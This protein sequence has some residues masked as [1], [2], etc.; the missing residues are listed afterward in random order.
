MKQ[1]HRAR[2][3]AICCLAV[4]G[5]AGTAS[6][7]RAQYGTIL[8]GQGP[9]NRSFA[10]VA[11]A[12]PLSPAGALYWNPATLPGLKST[13]LEAGVELIFPHTSASSTLPASAFGPGV[14]PVALTGKQNSLTTECALPTIG[15]AYL[16]EDSPF[17]FGLGAFAVAGFGVDYAGSTSNPALTAPQPNGVGFG[18]VYSDFQVLQ[19]VPAVAFRVTD[20]LSVSAG[21]TVD[22]ATLRGDPAIFAAPDDANRDGFATFPSGMHG[23]TVW[24]AGFFAGVF[25]QADKWAVGA[26]LKS[27]QWFDKF[28]FNSTD[29]LHRPRQLTLNLDLPMIISV[30]A[31]YTGLER[32]VFGVDARYIDYASANF[33]KDSGFAPDGAVSGLGWHSIFTLAAAAQYQLS[34]NLSIRLGYSWG[35]NPIPNAQAMVNTVSP[36]IA[37]HIGYAGATWNVTDQFSLSVACAH[38][39]E[40]AIHGPIVTRSGPIAGSAVR[41]TSAFDS[42]LI[43][44]TLKL[45]GPSRCAQVAVPV[46]GS[47]LQ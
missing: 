20:Q 36:V 4:L 30:G 6:L 43:G 2:R 29:E 21:P 8:T 27:P 33:L 45:G 5:L 23:R 19:I 14:P 37:E 25:Y 35:D 22:L 18:P 10:G 7:A 42:V 16:P 34:D 32:W 17:S 46:E 9:V 13:E 28:R 39:F 40:N 12:T 31:S 44:A 3:W 1:G 15:L 41:N 47:P 24:G 26:S 11:T 38:G